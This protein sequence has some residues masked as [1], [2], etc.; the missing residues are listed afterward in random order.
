LPVANLPEPK[1]ARRGEALTR[2][3]MKNYRWL[4]SELVA[5]VEFTERTD[6]NHLRHSRFVALRDDVDARQ[7][8]RDAAISASRKK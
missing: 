1:T 5:Q 6:A 2:H 7:V 4:K 3:T 8:T